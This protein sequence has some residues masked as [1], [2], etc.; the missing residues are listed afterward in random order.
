MNKSEALEIVASTPKG[1]MREKLLQNDEFRNI[2]LSS[3]ANV[4]IYEGDVIDGDNVKEMLSDISVG[5]IQRKNRKGNFDGLG[6]LGGLAER[7]SSEEFYSLSSSE[8]RALIGK[9]DDIIL[10][11]N[12]PSLIFDINVIRKNNVLREMSEELYDIGIDDITISPDRLELIPMSQV[13][14]DNYMINIWDGIGDCFA[15]NP[16]CHVYKD[17]RGLIDT[18]IAKS[19]EQ[20]AG[21]VSEYKKI[22][23]FEAL[24][25]YGNRENAQHTLED[26]RDA[27]KDYRYPHEYLTLWALSSK[28][29]DYDEEKM[30]SLA[31]ELQKDTNHLI[32]FSAIANATKQSMEDVA[33][34]LG[35]SID[36]L[37]RMEN[38]C[39]S[40]WAS[41]SMNAKFRAPDS[42]S[43]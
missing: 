10:V 38:V 36:T 43:H 37:N 14:D 9:K 12:I 4:T 2:V 1:G 40:N 25:G 31:S 15:I 27:R 23:L 5:L 24:K 6:A 17:D 34:V 30:V 26:G 20:E 39:K 19:N 13:K 28:L 42:F 33:D 29:L 3:G 35:V 11:D 41:K 32:S 22:A 18:I 21:E 7:T 16:Y 8:R